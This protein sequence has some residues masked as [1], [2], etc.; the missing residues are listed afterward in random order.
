[1]KKYANMCASVWCEMCKVSNWFGDV[2]LMHFLCVS[3]MFIRH[4]LMCT[5]IRCCFSH[6]LFSLWLHPA[7]LFISISHTIITHHQKNRKHWNNIKLQT[8]FP[9]SIALYD[10]PYSHLPLFSQ[11]VDRRY[12][13]NL[14]WKYLCLMFILFKVHTFEKLMPSKLY[15]VSSLVYSLSTFSSHKNHSIQFNAI[16][17]K[18]TTDSITIHNI[19]CMFFSYIR[20]TYLYR[21]C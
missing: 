15:C 2:S 17:H 4:A 9:N 5:H 8:Y 10:E 7:S 19:L 21:A 11:K 13:E 18:N 12:G 14:Y 3:I 6:L 1:M 20:Y 16:Q